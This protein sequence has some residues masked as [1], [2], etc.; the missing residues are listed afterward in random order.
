MRHAASVSLLSLLGVLGLLGVGCKSSRPKGP[1]VGWAPPP[2][3][4]LP[5]DAAPAPAPSYPPPA[6]PAPAEPAPAAPLLPAG[7]GELRPVLEGACRVRGVSGLDGATYV[8]ASGAS[9]EIRALRFVD[10][11]FDP[12]ASAFGTQVAG[13]FPGRTHFLYVGPAT[14]ERYVGRL[15]GGAVKMLSS[16]GTCRASATS[17]LGWACDGAKPAHLEA[18]PWLD[19]STLVLGHFGERYATVLGGKAA[20]PDMKL[21]APVVRGEFHS[22]ASL[23]A[24]AKGLAVYA[25]LVTWQVPKLSPDAPP[26]IR[27]QHVWIETSSPTK[28]VVSTKKKSPEKLLATPRTAPGPDGSVLVFVPGS[29]EVLRFDGDALRVLAKLP[30]AAHEVVETALTPSGEVYLLVEAGGGVPTAPGGGARSLYRLG[31]KGTLAAVALPD[32]LRTSRGGE[33]R[34]AV[35]RGTLWLRGDL[36]LYRA[37]GDAFSELTVAPLSGSSEARLRW[38]GSSGE[39]L[40]VAVGSEGTAEALYT[41]APTRG[42]ASCSELDRLTGLRWVR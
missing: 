7:S 40:W 3:L 21:A 23:T 2:Q 25:E 4:L 14:A 27:V 41:T 36:R 32:E 16:F 22:G 19:G 11:A 10:G 42:A 9:G 5:I 34:L 12:S 38:F 29:K 26:D 18:F 15:D 31:S 24:T 39:E 37:E 6:E 33:R 28:G 17:T 30:F 1:I 8:H 35:A 13:S 20:P